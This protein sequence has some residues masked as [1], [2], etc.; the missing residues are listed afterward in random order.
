MRIIIIITTFQEGKKS[1]CQSEN[2]I[3]G[4]HL[5]HPYVK[6][7]HIKAGHLERYSKRNSLVT[8]QLKKQQQKAFFLL[9]FE[10]YKLKT[11]NQAF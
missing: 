7:T 3:L 2:H 5:S 11:L 6:H 9:G 10:F 1:E 8:S 4:V